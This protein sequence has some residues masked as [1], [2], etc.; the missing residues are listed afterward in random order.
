MLC[1]DLTSRLMNLFGLRSFC[2]NLKA[3]CLEHF[4]DH[5]Q[6]KLASPTHI[7]WTTF[8]TAWTVLR[9]REKKLLLTGSSTVIIQILNGF[10]CNLTPR[11]MKGHVPTHTAVTLI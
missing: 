8:I 9:P 5:H 3:Y 11:K 4:I 6:S 10:S 1:A 2:P 7:L